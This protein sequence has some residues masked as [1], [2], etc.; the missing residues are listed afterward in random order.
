MTYE[1]ILV[2]THGKV[3]LVRLNRPQVLNALNDQLMTE[4]GNALMAFDADDNIGKLLAEVG[5]EVFLHGA[6]DPSTSPLAEYFGRHRHPGA[7][8]GLGPLGPAFAALG[9]SFRWD[10]DVRRGKE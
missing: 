9:P 2:E 4:L 7:S 1:T 3:G 5:P 8:W 6:H 10:D